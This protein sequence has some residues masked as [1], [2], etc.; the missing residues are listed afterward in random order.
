MLKRFLQNY[1]FDY[2]LRVDDDYFICL[3]RLLKELPHRPKSIY[4]GWVHCIPGMVRV[5]EGFLILSQDVILE[6]L[7]KVNDSLLCHPYGGQA[8]GHWM[9]QSSI[10][11][12]YFMDNDRLI[13]G[14]TSY[15]GSRYLVPD[16]CIKYLGL[17]GTYSDYMHKYWD[18]YTD[19]KNILQY[20]RKYEILPIVPFYNKCKTKAFDFNNFNPPYRATPKLCK[21]N[22]VFNGSGESFAGRERT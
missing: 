6:I 10:N 13:H 20:G 8:V 21:N 19:R 16:I 22:P 12:T 3:D 11:M 4:W 14:T 2:F 1:D 18:L 9:L 7:G 17:H 5:D 15:M